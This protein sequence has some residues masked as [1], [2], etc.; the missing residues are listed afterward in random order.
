MRLAL[1]LLLLIGGA[2]LPACQPSASRQ[3]LAPDPLPAAPAPNGDVTWDLSV[4]RSVTRIDWPDTGSND[5]YTIE[6]K[7]GDFDFRLC[8]K[9]GR[10]V[11]ARLQAVAARRRWG[12]VEGLELTTAPKTTLEAYRHAKEWLRQFQFP[13]EESAK[14]ETWLTHAQ[15]GDNANLKLQL[16]ESRQAFIVRLVNDGSTD[17]P[18]SVG[19]DFDWS[20]SCGCHD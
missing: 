17:K 9:D 10:T 6:G 14:L 3:A 4:D 16:A 1:R 15:A 8:L 18:W 5:Y 2:A 19:F 7:G 12:K 13:A 20:A 11:H